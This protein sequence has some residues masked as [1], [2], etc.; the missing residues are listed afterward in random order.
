MNNNSAS[1]ILTDLK[2]WLEMTERTFPAI[3]VNDLIF[4]A[5]DYVIAVLDTDY[6]GA[7]IPMKSLMQNLDDAGIKYQY[8]QDPDGTIQLLRY[9]NEQGCVFNVEPIK[10]SNWLNITKIAPTGN[11]IVQSGPWSFVFETIFNEWWKYN[12]PIA[13]VSN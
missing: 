9:R 1:D 7:H 8:N 12:N 5:L 11:K 13:R 3:K 4:E 2:K 10:D 6:P